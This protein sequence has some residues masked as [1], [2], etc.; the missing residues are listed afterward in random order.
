MHKNPRFNIVQAPG[1]CNRNFV[2]IEGQRTDSGHM[3]H[4]GKVLTVEMPRADAISLADKM[5]RE[6]AVAGA[7]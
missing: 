1:N 5:E 7:A 2:V 6:V 4:G 3:A